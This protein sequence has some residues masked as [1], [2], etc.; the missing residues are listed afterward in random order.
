MR[1]VLALFVFVT[2]A[3]CAPRALKEPE[4]LDMANWLSNDENTVTIDQGTIVGA[5]Y[6]TARAFYAIPYAQPPLGDLRFEPPQSPLP[7]TS[8]LHARTYGPGCPQDCELPPYTCTYDGTSEDCLTVDVYTPR[9]ATPTS[10]L[11]V[12]FFIHGGNFIQGGTGTIIYNADFI[13]NNTNVVVVNVQYRLGALGFFYNGDVSGNFG[14]LD[15]TMALQWVKNN[16]AAFGG[17]PNQVTIWGQSAGGN[18]VMCHM[19][20]PASQ[21]LMNAVAMDSNPITLYLNSEKLAN[22][23]SSRFAS[24]LGC[25]VSDLTCLRNQN[26]SAIVAAQAQAIKIY[27]LHPLNAFMPWQPMVDG[28]LIPMQPMSAISSGNYNHVPFI[29]GTVDNEA[30]MFIYSAFVD[31]VPYDDYLALV[32]LIFGPMAPRVL[33]EYPVPASQMNDTRPT[34]C[35]LGTAYIFHCPVRNVSRM[36]SNDSVPTYFYH[37]DHY[38]T[39]FNPWGPDYPECVDEVCHGSELPYIFNSAQIGHRYTGY[40]WSEQEAALAQLISTYWGNFA[41]SGNPNMPNTQSLTWPLY[42]ASTD[43]DLQFA[44]PSDVESGYMKSQCDF[45]DSIGYSW[46]N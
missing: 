9:G 36:I 20:S 13:A 32:G 30:V 44:T 45:W 24:I 22:E 11:P 40:V 8:T 31:P 19:I 46:G 35:E 3:T 26:T 7:F 15:Q 12:L 39:N 38:F 41:I 37:F 23:L 43:Q 21:G 27:P 28:Q 10:N 17:N 5:V 29:T 2:L 16:I 1:V 14:I 4:E 34:I 6:S 33:K 18:S 25:D 42:T